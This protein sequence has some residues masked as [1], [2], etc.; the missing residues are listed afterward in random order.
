[1]LE[2][3]EQPRI[4]EFITHWL[5]AQKPGIKGLVLAGGKSVRMQR[6]KGALEYHGV[7]QRTFIYQQFQQLGIA[8]Y[9]SCRQEQAE[10]ME[11]ELPLLLDSFEGLGPLGALLSAFRNDPDSAWLAIAC[12][13]PY[14]TL[15]TIKQLLDNRDSSQLATAFQSPFDEFPEPL[16]TI[17]EPRSYPV[18]LSFLSQGYS[19]PRKV[20]INSDIK[21][22]QA[23]NAKDLSNINHP[24]EYQ[25]AMADLG[26]SK[27]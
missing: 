24:D 23:E 20:L 25:R 12:D 1:V 4:A 2:W 18:L 26:L 10:E 14:L 16:I 13:L 22:I 9:V 5:S 27:I 21:L 11:K 15:D 17:W 7:N 8:G 3:E 6:D 19:C